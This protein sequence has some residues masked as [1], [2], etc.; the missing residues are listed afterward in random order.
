[1]RPSK[2]ARVPHRH[3]MAK[4]YLANLLLYP[5]DRCFDMPLTCSVRT[6]KGQN[7]ECNVFWGGGGREGEYWALSVCTL[8]TVVALQ[9]QHQLL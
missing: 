3:N 1:M 9:H 2:C 6:R 5:R 7:L 4:P 8:V